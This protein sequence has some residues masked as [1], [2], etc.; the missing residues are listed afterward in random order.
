MSTLHIWTGSGSPYAWRVLLALEHK[1]LDYEEHLLS[2]SQREHR[3]PAHLARNPRGKVP[4]LQHGDFVLYESSAILAYLEAAFPDRPLYGDTPQQVGRVAQRL[5]EVDTYLSPLAHSFYRP[6]FFADVEERRRD[7]E[8]AAGALHLELAGLEALVT[9]SAFLAGPV[10][11]AADYAAYPLL[12]LLLRAAG[13]P[14]VA[15]FELE[16][17]P[18]SLHYPA[19]AAWMGRIEQLPYFDRTWPPHWS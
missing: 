4:V 9:E 16:L 19:L 12:K 18:V 1:Q 11:S 14:K 5:A 8:R 15:D 2:F 13:K 17:L 3:A 10:V 7:I 6:I